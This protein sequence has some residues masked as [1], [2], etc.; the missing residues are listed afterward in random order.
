MSAWDSSGLVG[1]PGPI[2]PQGPQGI[3]GPAATIPINLIR[4]VK[5]SPVEQLIAH[6]TANVET[7]FGRISYSD[8][9]NVKNGDRLCINVFY[10]CQNNSG[11]MLSTLK[12]KHGGFTPITGATAALAASNGNYYVINWE[13]WIVFETIG[14]SLWAY[15]VFVIGGPGSYRVPAASLVNQTLSQ[16]ALANYAGTWGPSDAI[17]LTLTNTYANANAWTRVNGFVATLYPAP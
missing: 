4:V 14:T 15:G 10:T 8:M 13:F 12:L 9:P 2:G 16:S 11:S 17:I 3:Q 5:Q 6:P 7:E 1:P